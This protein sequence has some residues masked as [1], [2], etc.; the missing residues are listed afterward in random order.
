[1]WGGNAGLSV[2]G[3][4]HT[5]LELTF[6]NNMEILTD[7]KNLL[8]KTKMM[9]SEKRE[10]QTDEFG[11]AVEG[12]LLAIVAVLGVLG[13]LMC[14]LTFSLKRSKNTFHQLMIGKKND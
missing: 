8:N 9:L 11:Y 6:E 10:E 2:A 7:V 12:V 4:S 5:K 14:S 13:N 3:P 1:M